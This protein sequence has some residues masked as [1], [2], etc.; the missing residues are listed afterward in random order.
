MTEEDNVYNKSQKRETGPDKHHF[1]K[2]THA[3]AHTE[4]PLN[5]LSGVA[6][7]LSA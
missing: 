7:I 3:N 2:D 4:R 5:S 6:L 1:H